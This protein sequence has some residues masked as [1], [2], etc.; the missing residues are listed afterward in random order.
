[1][2]IEYIP[3]G[4]GGAAS[5]ARNPIHSYV[6]LAMPL[7]G[8]T[9]TNSNG[10]NAI[11]AYTA[12]S[13]PANALYGILLTIQNASANTSHCQVYLRVN[14]VVV[15]TGIYFKL[16]TSDSTQVLIP[17]KIPAG[18]TVELAIRTNANG[19]ARLFAVKGV[20]ANAIDAPGYSLVKNLTPD[21]AGTL[22]GTVNV[23]GTDTWIV[24][25]DVDDDYSA[26]MTTISD[27]GTAPTTGQ[28]NTVAYGFGTPDSNSV[29]NPN[30]TGAVNG[31][32]GTMPTNTNTVNSG[33]T[34]T[35]VGTGTVSGVPYVDIRFNGTTTNTFANILLET[36]G[37]IAAANG[38]HWTV[39]SYIAI[40]GG[41]LANITSIKHRAALYD[42]ALAYLGEIAANPVD[43]MGSLDAT[44]SRRIGASGTIT[45]A[46]AASINPYIQLTFA[47]GAAIDITLRIG[48]P[49]LAQV[50]APSSAFWRFQ[51]RFSTAQPYIVQALSP[52]VRM[53]LP[54]RSIIFSKVTCPVA[55]SVSSRP[56]IIGFK[57]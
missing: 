35:I 57:S 12:L 43:V 2:G 22:A 53:A 13:S 15:I 37:V 32:P 3:F 14:G 28:M 49:F 48:L 54:K 18:A 46:T 11:S 51:Q 56:G 1:M 39:D 44:L 10:A 4:A 25:A 30:L 38:Q 47:N 31:S 9:I 40:V 5:Q 36:V 16:N 7:G 6:D 24:S 29:R 45:S 55:D 33:L 27:S 8:L 34:R 42:G 21:T 20:E 17:I 26:F 50:A 23:P 41:S 52:V 19:H